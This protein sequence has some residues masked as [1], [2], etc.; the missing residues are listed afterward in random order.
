MI[1]TTLVALGLGYVMGL[2]QGGIKIYHGIKPDKKV[3]EQPK[4]NE[5]AQIPPEVENYFNKTQGYI[6]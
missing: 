4:Y 1:T 5:A 3:D 6:E 2:M